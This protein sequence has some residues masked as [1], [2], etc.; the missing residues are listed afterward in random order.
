ML[1]NIL[2]KKK[3]YWIELIYGIFASGFHCP[4]DA[5]VEQMKISRTITAENFQTFCLVHSG[6]QKLFYLHFRMRNNF[7]D[8]S[9]TDRHEETF[10]DYKEGI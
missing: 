2:Q 10:Q 7:S 4:A 6:S 3:P 1:K 5:D 8:K 9:C